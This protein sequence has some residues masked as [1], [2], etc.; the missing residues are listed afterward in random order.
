[1]PKSG[2]WSAPEWHHR[3]F[4]FLAALKLDIYSFGVTILWLVFY[5]GQSSDDETFH[6]FL[7]SKIEWPL[8]TENMFLQN[9]C[10]SD[11]ERRNLSDLLNA[12]IAPDP[13]DRTLNMNECYLLLKG[14][15]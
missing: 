2:L 14:Q 7:K 11:R 15:T 1:M 9:A 12:T 13:R 8:N 6:R 4:S 3:G 5:T 10:V